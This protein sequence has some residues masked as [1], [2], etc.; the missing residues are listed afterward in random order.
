M[1]QNNLTISIKE[2][3]KAVKLIALVRM[4]LAGE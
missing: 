4:I 3:V 2:T 1:S